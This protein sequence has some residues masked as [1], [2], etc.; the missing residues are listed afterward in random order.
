MQ[1]LKIYIST[2]GLYPDNTGGDSKFIR[3]IFDE[4]SKRGHDIT[5]LTAQWNDGF[6]DPRVIS[7]KVPK[8][9]IVWAPKFALKFRKYIKKNDFDILHANGSRG[10]IPILLSK[11]PFVTH[12]HDVGPFQAKF[13]SIPGLKW[14]EKQNAR[15]AKLIMTCSESTKHEISQYMKVEE[16][17]IYNVSS[18]IDPHFKPEPQKAEELKNKLGLNGPVIFY[19][20]RIAFYK[21][22][23]DIIK[24]YKIAKKQFPD[25]NLVIGGSPTLKMKEIY[26]KW[27]KE[28]KDIIFTGRIPDE[29]LP[30]YYSMADIFT[31]YSY[32][33]EGFGLTPVEALACGTPVICSNL[34][35]YKNVLKEYATFVEPRKPEL[36]ANAFIEQ[37][38]NPDIGLQK[39][40]GAENLLKIYSWPN[41]A[42]NV[43]HVYKIYLEKYK[44]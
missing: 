10:S 22:I 33:S 17:K 40:K 6:Q 13:T 7:I 28:Y 38:K 5:V 3:G 27:R 34:P 42:D 35:A 14:L 24:A 2:M 25:L 21:G 8:I 15:K 1:K 44:K 43:E 9:R 41:V 31:T 20:G 39:V 19:V 18:A 29:L 30:A 12:I 32:A 4:L 37:L 23:D 11:K 26:E 36:L 16:S